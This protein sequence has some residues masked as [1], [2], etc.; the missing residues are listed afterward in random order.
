M[1]AMKND[2]HLFNI[3]ADKDISTTEDLKMEIV[4]HIDYLTSKSDEPAL[5][6]QEFYLHDGHSAL[7]DDNI[8]HEG[9]TSVVLMLRLLGGAK[10][11]P[12]QKTKKANILKVQCETAQNEL[13][14]ITPSDGLGEAEKTIT[15]FQSQVH[16]EPVATFKS[17]LKSKNLE[18]LKEISLDVQSSGET[19]FRN[20]AHLFLGD[21]LVKLSKT[22]DDNKKV[23]DMA[24]SVVE[25]GWA[26]TCEADSAFNFTQFKKELDKVITFNEWQMSSSSA[27]PHAMDTSG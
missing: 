20:A 11:T 17:W 16:G 13:K 5:T 14:K 18:N 4:K 2:R 10:M 23:L 26:R 15:L 1:Y 27:Y 24:K 6:S 12:A 21:V 3:K 22:T 19:K 8:V 25:W 7:K 9:L